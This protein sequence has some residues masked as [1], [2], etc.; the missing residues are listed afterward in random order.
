MCE[1]D[2]AFQ[3]TRSDLSSP[4]EVTVTSADGRETLL[5]APLVYP[6][7]DCGPEGAR[8][9]FYYP[10]EWLNDV[11][12]LGRSPYTLE[13]ALTFR[14]TTHVGTTTWQARGRSP[15]RPLAVER[16]LPAAGVG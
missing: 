6:S 3:P 15:Y 8:G 5:T 4:V 9:S 16:P 10:R 13:D 2:L 11:S 1:S 14:G 7:L 12:V